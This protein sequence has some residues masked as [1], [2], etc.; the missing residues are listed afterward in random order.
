MPVLTHHS[1]NIERGGGDLEA[2][3]WGSIPCAIS[4]LLNLLLAAKDTRVCIKPLSSQSNS[5]TSDSN[6]RY[7]NS[8]DRFEAHQP[9]TCQ[10]RTADT[11]EDGMGEGKGSFLSPFSL[12][13][14]FLATS[15]SAVQF[16]GIGKT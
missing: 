11:S 8:D 6:Y 16:T 13:F 7:I 14:F 4:L 3:M 5:G 10:R 1:H 2:D 9:C 12:S 15:L